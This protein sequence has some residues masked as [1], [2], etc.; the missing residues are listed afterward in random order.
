MAREVEPG[1]SPPRRPGR[2]PG[3]AAD[4]SNRRRRASRKGRGQTESAL[5]PRPD[6]IAS[7]QRR[8]WPPWR[9]RAGAAHRAAPPRFAAAAPRGAAS[10]E[11]P[12]L[13]RVGD[14][15]W[16]LSSQVRLGGLVRRRLIGGD[17]AAGSLFR[18]RGGEDDVVQVLFQAAAPAEGYPRGAR[19]GDEEAGERS[20]EFRVP[21]RD[22]RVEQLDGA[23]E[24]H[25]SGDQQREA[26]PGEDRQGPW[27][28]FQGG[29]RSSQ[30]LIL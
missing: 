12:F 22:E 2:W 23:E 6:R 24:R 17:G 7:E 20:V 30:R 3:R 4:P 16:R 21:Q 15:P 27:P 1:A 10:R 11:G 8:R 29:D 25:R 9:A 26:Q 19:A 13:P 18:G 5:P 14:R 28:T